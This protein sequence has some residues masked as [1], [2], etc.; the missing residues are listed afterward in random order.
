MARAAPLFWGLVGGFC[1]FIF[2]VVGVL[3]GYMATVHDYSNR[4]LEPH[5]SVTWPAL[6]LL[7]WHRIRTHRYCISIYVGLLQI[8]Y[9]VLGNWPLPR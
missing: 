3:A 9:G 8:H 6:S 1:I 5:G 7:A 4:Y 2:G